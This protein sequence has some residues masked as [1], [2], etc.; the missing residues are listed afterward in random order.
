[1]NAVVAQ[2]T[3]P[4]QKCKTEGYGALLD[5]Q[6]S[7]CVAGAGDSAPCEKLAKREGFVAVSKTM[8][9]VAH[10][11][12]IWKDECRVQAQYKSHMK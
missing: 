10:L 12:T 7:F 1:V 2:S 8:A 4:S 3:F 6:M 9:G 5:V 11:K